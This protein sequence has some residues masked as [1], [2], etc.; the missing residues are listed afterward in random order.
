MRRRC[1]ACGGK[2]FAG[3]PLPREPVCGRCGYNLTGNSSGVCPE[4]GW[5]IPPYVRQNISSR[6]I[7]Q[8]EKHDDRPPAGTR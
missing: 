8:Q 4:C 6:E 3:T 5:A 2:F 7:T 1:R